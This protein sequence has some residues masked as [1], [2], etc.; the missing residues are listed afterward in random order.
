[1]QK[2]N[3]FVLETMNP[4]G[5][6]VMLPKPRG[7]TWP[8]AIELAGVLYQW[9]SAGQSAEAGSLARAKDRVWRFALD[10]RFGKTSREGRWLNCGLAA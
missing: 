6:G 1:M 2:M 9:L 5:I 4:A 7:L 10:A 8:A 3:S